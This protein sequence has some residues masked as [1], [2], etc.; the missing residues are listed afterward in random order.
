MLAL[1]LF[2]F[3][4]ADLPVHCLRHQVSLLLMAQLHLIHCSALTHG[5]VVHA[6]AL[7]H[8]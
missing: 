6:V 2:G 8:L 7:I 5:L 3:V 1:T 4:V